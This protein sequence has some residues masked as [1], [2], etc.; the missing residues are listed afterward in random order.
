MALALPVAF[1]SEVVRAALI[2]RL[3]EMESVHLRMPL[4]EYM[5][6]LWV[7]VLAG[8]CFLLACRLT[9]GHK[10][11][12]RASGDHGTPHPPQ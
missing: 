8:C 11:F 3:R 6:L 1:G 12:T 5:E 9:G 4:F 10:L 2:E 7:L